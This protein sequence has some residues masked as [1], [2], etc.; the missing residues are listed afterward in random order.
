[1]KI[2]RNDLQEDYDRRKLSD[3]RNSHTNGPQDSRSKPLQFFHQE[4]R[5]DLGNGEHCERPEAVTG[6]CILPR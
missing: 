3:H 5:R 4:R 6:S 1:M 2:M